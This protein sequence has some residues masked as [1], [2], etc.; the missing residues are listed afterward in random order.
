LLG[1]WWPPRPGDEAGRR[2][3]DRGEPTFLYALR[4]DDGGWL[5]EETSLAARPALPLSLLEDRLG[6]RLDALGARLGPVRAVEHVHIPMGAGVP[7]PQRVV[8]FGAAGGLVHPATGY[9][10]AASLRVAPALAR[11]VADGLARRATPEAVAA[12]GWA[13]VWPSGR[14]RARALEDYGLGALLRLDQAGAQD[15]FDAFFSVEREQWAPY[16][17]GTAS[18]GEVSSLMRRV[19]A[20]APWRVRTRLAT[21]DVRRLAPGLRPG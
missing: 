12:A 20:A 11:A 7:R 21:G 3:L 2:P 19:F 17:A 6:A 1:D 16:L 5:L 15:F 10:V 4:L 9:S 8:G 18:P 13:A 14:R